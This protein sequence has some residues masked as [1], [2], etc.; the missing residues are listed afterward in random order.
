MYGI[1]TITRLLMR[2]TGAANCRYGGRGT[3]FSAIWIATNL[4]LFIMMLFRGWMDYSVENRAA[5]EC[6]D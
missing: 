4:R 3:S 2:R 6:H 5:S 1:A